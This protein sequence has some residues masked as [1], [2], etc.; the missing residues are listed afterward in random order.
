MSIFPFGSTSATTPV[1]GTSNANHL[2]VPDC[3]SFEIVFVLKTDAVT[4]LPHLAT[5]VVVSLSGTRPEAEAAG[6]SSVSSLQP[7][8][9][10]PLR[11]GT[12]SGSSPPRSNISPGKYTR[13]A[14]ET[15]PPFASKDTVSCS[16]AGVHTKSLSHIV[17]PAPAE[18]HCTLWSDSPPY[19][20]T[21]YVSQLPG[22]CPPEAKL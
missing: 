4:A 14:A 13:G 22:F 18:Y 1:S 7:R 11:T 9:V 17:Q 19:S 8:N 10:Y 5:S 15:V 21:L 2:S 12:G 16:G 20:E 6:P 3:L